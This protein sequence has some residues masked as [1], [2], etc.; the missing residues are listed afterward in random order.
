MNVS[1]T[2]TII[3]SAC[4]LLSSWLVS[5]AESTETKIEWQ[6]DLGLTV[7]YNRHFIEGLT[8][9]D[10]SFGLSPFV[11]GGVYYGKFYAEASPNTLHPLTFGYVLHDSDSHQFNLV[12]ESWFFEISE[13]NQSEDSSNL[14][15]IITRKASFEAGVEYISTNHKYDFRVRLLHDALGRHNGTV[16]TIEMARPIYTETTLW[17]PALSIA[18]V[19]SNAVDYYYGVHASEVRVG[20]PEYT[21]G[22]A[23]ITAAQLYVE[24]PFGERWSIIGFAGIALPSR[25]ITESPLVTPRS[26]GFNVG[27]GAIW[28]F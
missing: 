7:N 17:L 19:S 1:K 16:A 2:V 23:Y 15:G 13:E 12:A 10:D 6:V 14:D 8:E 5:A 28:T 11:S 20:R 4:L 3:F 26:N 9:R 22:S 27:V 18:F 21:A 25:N 24:R